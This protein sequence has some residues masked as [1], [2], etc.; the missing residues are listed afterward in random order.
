M[1]TYFESV[2]QTGNNTMFNTVR[3]EVKQEIEIS[4]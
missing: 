3:N 1:G 4:K 2:L